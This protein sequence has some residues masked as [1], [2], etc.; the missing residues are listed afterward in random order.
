M[1]SETIPPTWQ[2]MMDQGSQSST[3]TWSRYRTLQGPVSFRLTDV[4]AYDG[5]RWYCADMDMWLL[6]SNNNIQG[7]GSMRKWWGQ[8]AVCVLGTFQPARSLKLRT[9]VRIMETAVGYGS[10]TAGT[11]GGVLTW[12]PQ[13][14]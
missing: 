2:P 1:P 3:V 14:S 11:W 8:D 5:R 12:T 10:I 6:D 4:S 7:S 9:R 13:I